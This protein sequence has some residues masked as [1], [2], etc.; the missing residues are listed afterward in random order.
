MV[1]GRLVRSSGSSFCRWSKRGQ[2]NQV[3]S[4]SKGCFRTKLHL[5]VAF[6][7]NPVRLVL[8]GD[9]VHDPQQSMSLIAGVPAGNM[10]ADKVNHCND[11]RQAIIDGGARQVI[12][13]RSKL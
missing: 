13:P 6:F 8:N 12:P 10:I 3:L 5:A 9:E 7:R 2:K 4:R 1:Y 11:F